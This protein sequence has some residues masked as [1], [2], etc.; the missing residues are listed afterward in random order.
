MKWISNSIAMLGVLAF[1]TVCTGAAYGDTDVPAFLHKRCGYCHGGRNPSQQ[2]NLRDKAG[3][4]AALV[5]V[6]SLEKP[7]LQLVAPGD[8]GN[9]Y[10][11]QKMHG[12][13]G[14]KGRRMP[15]HRKAVTPEIIQAVGDWIAAMKPGTAK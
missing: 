5:N 11:L 8:P 1:L 7:E 15:L 12:D 3:L 4:G 13:A 2:L 14:I 9:S 10:L 6:A